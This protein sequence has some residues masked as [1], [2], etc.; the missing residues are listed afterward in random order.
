M[1]EAYKFPDEQEQQ[2]QD[3]ELE[4][5][6]EEDDIELEVVDDTPE[7]DRGRKPLDRDVNDP[8]DEEV[9]EYSDKVQKRMRELTHA[10]H[11]ERRAKEAALREREEAARVAEQLLAENKR[12]RD[13]FQAGAETYT[14]VVQSQ[15]DMELQMARQKLKAAQESYDTDAI[16]AAQEEL[17]AA[18]Y[19]SEAAKAYKPPALQQPE[20]EVYVT[21]TQQQPAV[22]LTDTDVKWQARN[23]WF[24]QDDEMTALAYAVHKKLVNA[25]VRAGT[26][27]YYERVDARMRE[28]FPDFF[29]ETKK[30]TREVKRPATV[31]AAP[32]R[33][34]AKKTQVTLTK[35]QEAIARRLGLTNKQYAT[36]VLKLNSES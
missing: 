6:T 21:P 4:V 29:G 32:T 12:L 10:R 28:V 9:A 3:E 27:E 14:K 20:K 11:D 33:T 8:T 24:G 22:Q 16:I 35:S 23:Q 18:K 34:A 5:R 36:E 30:E 2:G 7:E 13:Q 17:A 26:P 19:R 15:A 1:P 25:G 31:V